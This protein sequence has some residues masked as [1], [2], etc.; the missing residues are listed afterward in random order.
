MGNTFFISDLHISH[1]NVLEYDQRPFRT[2]EEN[3]AE[4]MRRWNEKVDDDDDV[5]ILGDI[6]WRKNEDT[7]AYY[8]QLRGKKHLIVGNHDKKM[9]KDANVARLFV[10]ILDYKE[11][12]FDY[13]IDIVL[14]HYPIPCFKNHFHGWLHFYGHVHNSFESD[15]IEKFRREMEE[16]R[17]HACRMFNVG[18]MMP[19]INYT[20]M[21]WEEIIRGYNE[22]SDKQ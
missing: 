5:Y 15:M 2:I 7:V 12:H 14:C 18:C 17:H 19:Y 9:I 1:K 16:E 10:E 21:S 4:I 8:K 20:P 11:F 6:S 13:G 22:W 3:D